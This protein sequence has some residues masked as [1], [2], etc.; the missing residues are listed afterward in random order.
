MPFTA[1]WSKVPED[2]GHPSPYVPAMVHHCRRLYC[3][4]VLLLESF[5]S[6][7]KSRQVI[8]LLSG[9]SEGLGAWGLGLIDGEDEGEGEIGL[10]GDG[11]WLWEGLSD[12]LPDGPGLAE[13]DGTTGDGLGVLGLGLTD[14]ENEGEEEVGLQGDELGLGLS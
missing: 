10:Q 7:G 1:Y 11:L 8:G 12:E 2:D 6:A 13:A 9:D 4:H 3:S 5:Q 14:G